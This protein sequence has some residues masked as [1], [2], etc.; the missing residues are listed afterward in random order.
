[1]KDERLK[2]NSKLPFPNKRPCV[3]LIPN[4]GILNKKVSWNVRG[5][6]TTA[7]MS[8]LSGKLRTLTLGVHSHSSVAGTEASGWYDAPPEIL[9]RIF[10]LSLPEALETSLAIP[11]LP[12]LLLTHTCSRWRTI[13]HT[14]PIL[15]VKCSLQCNPAV[16]GP[17]T[18]EKL[19]AQAEL[20]LRRCGNRGV[21][22]RL[23]YLLENHEWNSTADGRHHDLLTELTDR[24]PFVDKVRGLDIVWPSNV[25]AALPGYIKALPHLESFA[26]DSLVGTYD[27]YC[28]DR[29]GLALS[30]SPLFR[31][32]HIGQST[33]GPT[34][35]SRPRPMHGDMTADWPWK[36]LTHLS[37]ATTQLSELQAYKLLC[38]CKNL[39][40][41]SLCIE[42]MTQF[43]ERQV[44]G[45]DITLPFL[46]SLDIR[47]ISWP[48]FRILNSA[49]VSPL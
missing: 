16:D 2:A 29:D 21:T 45:V 1:M 28:R 13:A 39:E 30:S 31:R 7:T 3:R 42:R 33:Q 26:V 4:R 14:T 41:V 23:R 32:L 27:L 47:F 48:T 44:E 38:L 40:E 11:S 35:N 8:T 37:L 10:E 5:F 46:H 49:I 9:T 22:L 17:R 24:N 34:A 15:W 6:C 18:K 20:W 25:T 19:M 43:D 36:Q 12:P